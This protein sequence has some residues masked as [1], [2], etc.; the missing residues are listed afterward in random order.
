MLSIVPKSMTLDD[1]EWPKRQRVN[2]TVISNLRFADDISLL[3]NN[4]QDLQ[5]LV[6]NVN[7]TSIRFGLTISG[8]ETE[9]QVF[10]RDVSQIQ[11]HM[12]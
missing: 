5:N 2:R 4:N 12:L 8:S 10:G 6:D 11:M 7:R 1:L 9:V 3:A